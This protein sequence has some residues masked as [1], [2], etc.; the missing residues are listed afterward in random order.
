MLHSSFLFTAKSASIFSV[1]ICSLKKKK[2]KKKKKEEEEEN[3]NKKQ[4]I[5]TNKPEDV[6]YRT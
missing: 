1:L 2:K 4:Q 3:K 6:K 5:K